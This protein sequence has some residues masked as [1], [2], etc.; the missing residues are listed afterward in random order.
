MATVLG[1]YSNILEKKSK[2]YS[3]LHHHLKIEK[4][5]FRFSQKMWMVPLEFPF[6][7][8]FIHSTNKPHRYIF[9]VTRRTRSTNRIL[10]SMELLCPAKPPWNSLP[11]LSV[12]YGIAEQSQLQRP[13]TASSTRG[14]ACISMHVLREENTHPSLEIHLKANRYGVFLPLVEKFYFSNSKTWIRHSGNELVFGIR[15]ALTKKK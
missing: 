13:E 15:N 2:K 10:S 8:L 1:I 11:N 6:W 4:Q 7:A 5:M 9:P 3:S 12:P 14:R